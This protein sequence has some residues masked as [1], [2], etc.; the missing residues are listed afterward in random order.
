MFNFN[1]KLFQKIYP[2]FTKSDVK[3]LSDEESSIANTVFMDGLNFSHSCWQFSHINVNI[4]NCHAELSTIKFKYLQFVSVE[5]CVDGNWKFRDVQNVTIKHCRNIIGTDIPMLL[6]FDNSS[7]SVK[8]VTV[9]DAN[10]T[11]WF[12]SIIVQNFSFLD[13]TKSRLVNNRAKTRVIKVLNSSTLSLSD[14]NMSKNQGEESAGV[15]FVINSTVHIRNSNLT[16]NKAHDL[17]GAIF[18]ENESFV[19]IT[20]CTFENNEAKYGGVLAG[21][22]QHFST[23]IK[24][25]NSSFL[26]NHATI[27][28]GALHVNNGLQ[29]FL[30][31]SYFSNNTA[32][33]N[34]GAIFTIDKSTLD[35]SSSVFYHNTARSGGA[36]YFQAF[37]RATLN[38]CTFVD[39]SKTAV[40]VFNHTNVTIEKCRF[41]NNSSPYNGGAIYFLNAC[42]SNI[43]HTTFIQNSARQ[44]S[45]VS[46]ESHSF[47][48]ISYCSFSGNIAVSAEYGLNGT[49]ETFIEFFRDSSSGGGGGVSISD[50]SKVEISQSHFYN[51]SATYSG[52][53][54]LATSNSLLSISFATFENNVAGVFGGAIHGI[55]NSSV[56]LKESS[57]KS[58]S[59]STKRMGIG[60]GVVCSK[61]CTTAIFNVHFL[62]NK[63]QYGGAIGAMYTS[64]LMVFNNL[65]VFNMG[66]A[67]FLAEGSSLDIDNS[68]FINN[69]TPLKGGAVFAYRQHFINVKNSNFIKNK[70]MTSGGAIHIET[71]GYASIYNCLF[72]D[73]FSLKGGAITA[74]DSDTQI[75]YS[76]FT[77]NSATN[78]G[79]LASD[80]LI[81]MFNCMVKNNSAR[82][83][84]ASLYLDEG[85]KIN[86]TNSEFN[87]NSAFGAGGVMWITKGSVVIKNSSFKKNIAGTNGGVISAKHF[88]VVNIVQTNFYENKA[89]GGDGSVLFGKDTTRV[90]FN[91]TQIQQN[92]GYS[93][94]V[95]RIDGNFV[96]E[97]HH[98]NTESNTGEMNSGAYLISN[99]SLF[100]ATHSSFKGNS[101]FGPGGI[102]LAYST[103]YF[104]NCK[105]T[106]NNGLATGGA[107]A[108]SYVDLKISARSQSTMPLSTTHLG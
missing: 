19:Q 24:C 65:F 33:V 35:I 22:G 102:Y 48:S 79:V 107:I 73:N 66:T 99:N 31:A 2:L 91:D 76:N 106:G 9:E 88:C 1:G 68:S 80:G 69:S 8:N 92:F 61:N 82:G 78:S 23:M 5:N 63:A 43:S 26:N 11:R 46:V 72:S 41:Q 100:I 14:C 54:L 70:G 28:G 34:G 36:I 90:F 67:T 10:N 56:I 94:G 104:E 3:V 45:A 44:G 16:Q 60:G 13:I 87:E 52:A 7:A 101:G 55:G 18:I 20:N 108:I 89:K 15:L 4:K 53:A 51:N 29:I 58:N 96:L 47:I 38:N 39:N 42:A 93:S 37:S 86:I 30:I 98:T 81:L 25:E 6:N 77:K 75:S 85:S 71:N 12:H 103:G 105:L 59:L 95:M 50:Y 74:V 57:L 62:K 40:M 21:N 27:S 84:G 49:W 64:S 17:G 32:A 83:D 97:L